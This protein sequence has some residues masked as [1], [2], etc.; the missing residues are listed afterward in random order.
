[1]GREQDLADTLWKEI[2]RTLGKTGETGK[3]TFR[4]NALAYQKVSA[5]VEEELESLGGT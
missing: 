1:M 4:P 2:V 3:V 5:L